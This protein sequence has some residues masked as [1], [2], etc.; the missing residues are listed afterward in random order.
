MMVAK[1]FRQ[2]FPKKKR[3]QKGQ[4]SIFLGTLLLTVMSLLAFVINVGLF[5]KAKINLQNAVDAAAWSGAAVQARQLTNISYLNWE[6]RNTYKEWMFK[7]YVV[8]QLGLE[9]THLHNV[10]GPT[11][12]FGQ[13][14]STNMNFR[15]NP[16]WAD[17]ANP[18]GNDGSDQAFDKFNLPSAC[19]HFGSANNICQI[20]DVP[21]LP[22]FGSEG[23]PSIS[24]ANESFLNIMTS[25]KAKNCTVRSNLN[26][27]SAMTWTY[28]IKK[29]GFNDTVIAG[30]RLGAWPEAL[31][32]GFRM[33][34]LEFLANRPPIE[35]GVCNTS[36]ISPGCVT[37][38]DLHNNQKHLDFGYNDRPFR[39]FT[40]AYKNL[41]EELKRT[42]ILKEVA[43]KA[44]SAQVD[45]LSGYL[46]K[47]VAHDQGSNSLTKFYVDL[48]MMPINYAVFFT[49]FV[50]STRGGD[51]QQEGACSSTK[52]A[53]PVPG[54]VLGFVK[55]PE[56]LTY[57]AV[58]GEARH[59]GL[60][61]P[62]TEDK[63]IK[64]TAYAAAKPFGGRIG[65][66]LFNVMKDKKQ[67]Y[68]REGGFFRSSA[69]M[70]SLQTSSLGQN[71]IIGYPIP[72]DPNHKF[73]ANDGD[74]VGGAPQASS[75]I[76][77][78]IPNLLYDYLGDMR[79]QVGSGGGSLNG[80]LG[81]V[82]KDLAQAYSNIDE[83]K[84]LYRKDQFAAFSG[85]LPN[86]AGNSQAT[87]T[88]Q[89]IYDAIYS[90]RS[91][92]AYEAL[93]YLIPSDPAN[94]IAEGMDSASLVQGSTTNGLF[95]YQIYA[96]LFG[97][98][99]LYNS[100]PEVVIA[101]NQFLSEIKS[102]VQKFVDTLGEV[103]TSIRTQQTAGADFTAAAKGIS[104]D[105][106]NECNS[107]A[108][109][110]NA[111]FS[112]SK[113]IGPGCDK[114]KPLDQH[115]SE[116]FTDE[117]TRNPEFQ[118]H[119][120]S[121]FRNNAGISP[122][123]PQQRNWM[124][125]YAPGT[126]SGAKNNSEIVH[127]LLTSQRPRNGQRNFYSTKLVGVAQL[128]KS[129]P[130]SYSNK[131][132]YAEGPSMGDVGVDIQGAASSFENPLNPSDF[133]EFGNDLTF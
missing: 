31:E 49:S 11:S 6:L 9:K 120:F 12:K 70:S 7:Y 102:P 10:L 33:R 106:K 114:I 79:G 56:V 132:M 1:C 69:Y 100:A 30:D 112:P 41:G 42:F 61:F 60:F 38:T 133:S 67:V 13:P 96:P 32:L 62:F 110:F 129:G 121:T 94:N 126:F 125:A 35:N 118:T 123:F 84:G 28:G 111:F 44:Y 34:N 71:F 75:G 98:G 21:G 18:L 82:R 86:L 107:I 116:Y 2:I 95:N 73:W 24:E 15:A 16:F 127:P 122:N 37:A 20:Q 17:G 89:N 5:V 77:F 48:K 104:D 124:T 108:G 101:V 45:D 59:L 109:K 74:A 22:R 66:M 99:L 53:I 23:L 103:A 51:V 3:S 131:L 65:P 47:N 54:Y 36:T 50:N 64:I 58:K 92:T 130:N 27:A 113:Q 76:F 46:I 97:T 68:P 87:I 117:P 43:P 55:N 105:P 119:Y 29:A 25:E 26:F 90:A 52:M 78:G 115:M 14:S 40:A 39:A 57:Y 72:L 83:G 4:L 81:I 91:P 93:N 85:N 8:G 88:T 63:G 80:V 19:I 128:L